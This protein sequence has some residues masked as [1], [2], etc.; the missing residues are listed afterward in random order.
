MPVLV[1]MGWGGLVQAPA[2]ITWT[3]IT[4]RV[5]MMQGVTITRGAS[6]ELS[7][8]QPGTATLTLDNQDGAL[9]PGNPN[10]PYYPFVRRN[11]PIRISQAIMPTRTGA[12]P[13]P[14]GMLADDFD[15]GIVD[16]TLS[17]ASGGSAEVGG[18]LRQP[19]ASGV[20]ARHTSFR[21]WNL[22]GSMLAVK[23]C[24]IP[25][26]NGSSSTSVSMWIYSQT[27]GTRLR[28]SCNAVGNQLRA[29]LEVASTDA[30]AISVPY[31]PI[32]HAWLRIRELSG[33]LL[34]ETSPDGFEWTVV[35]SLATPARVGTDVT[36]VEF[37]ATRTG[38]TIDYVEWDLL[39]AQIKPRFWGW[40][41]NGPLSG[42]GCCPRSRSARQTSSSASTGCRRSA[43]CWV[44]RS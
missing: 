41:T 30:G 43:A 23:L 32:A 26:I 12:A 35:R 7:E 16:P 24:T 6:D 33:F 5:D 17:T 20:V 3:D 1:E 8:T 9:T 19:L 14:M 39:G 27:A 25:G 40:S 15:D 34:W 18:R 10:S 36:Q 2:T 31:D 22:A 44:W 11:A 38:G 21:E 29:A 4:P 13:Y 42:R 28:W 37:T